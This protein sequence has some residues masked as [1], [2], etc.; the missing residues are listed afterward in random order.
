[1]IEN[2]RKLTAEFLKFIANIQ[3]MI[4]HLMWTVALFRRVKNKLG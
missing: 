3:P 1:M 4:L 2:Y